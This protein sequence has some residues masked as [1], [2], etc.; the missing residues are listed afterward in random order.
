MWSHTWMQPAGC[1]NEEAARWAESRC[2]RVY[3][4]FDSAFGGL[5]V[6]FLKK[7][8]VNLWCGAAPV[9][10]FLP[11]NLTKSDD[12][13][14]IDDVCPD[15]VNMSP[16]ELLGVHA[17]IMARVAQKYGWPT[18]SIRQAEELAASTGVIARKEL[19]AVRDR[20]GVGVA[21]A[22]G[23]IDDDG[24]HVELTASLD[25][26]DPRTSVAHSWGELEMLD[27]AVGSI[28]WQTDGSVTLNPQKSIFK[29]LKP[30]TIAA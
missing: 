5:D 27:L 14:L 28:T 18:D 8:A 12:V 9:P 16:T 13:L 6:P 20:R 17:D 21:S 29:H 25:G 11:E 10:F 30:L 26:S 15:I 1:Q 22:R 4:A 3:S 24:L 23:W 19:S 7:V 2:T